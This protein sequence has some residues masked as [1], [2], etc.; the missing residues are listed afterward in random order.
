MIAL[1]DGETLVP[2]L[3]SQDHKRALEGDQ[4]PNTGG[5]GAYAPVSLVDDALRDRILDE[6]FRPTLAALAAQ[7]I[8]FTGTLYAGLML[9]EDGPKVLEWNVRFGDPEAQAIL[10]LLESDL[11]E[12]LLAACANPVRNTRSDP[13]YPAWR[14]G[15]CVTVVAAC[16]GYPGDYD[17][18][19]PIW[20]PEDLAAPDSFDR[21]GL[22]IFHAGTRREAGRLLTAGGR[23]L[24]VTAIGED[25]DD[26]RS[27]AYAALDRIDAPALRTRPDIGWREIARATSTGSLH[28]PT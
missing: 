20:I 23:V 18:G 21:N 25:I 27:K 24:A 15:I 11:L 10:P 14:P 19:A 26:A 7:G 16:E 13:G 6:I 2:L 5:M 1:T 12:M 4:G 3:S 28:P 9:T 22:V 8:R 17:I